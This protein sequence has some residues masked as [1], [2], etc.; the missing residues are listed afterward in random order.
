MS[1]PDK[2]FIVLCSRGCG[3][4]DGFMHRGRGLACANCDAAAA[5]YVAVEVVKSEEFANRVLTS[6]LASTCSGM[7]DAQRDGIVRALDITER[8]TSRTHHGEPS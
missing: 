6:H 1:L 4:V 8:A 3:A 7:A 2:S 5:E